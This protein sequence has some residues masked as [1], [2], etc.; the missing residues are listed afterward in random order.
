MEHNAAH[1][2]NLC[3]N[4]A[5]WRFGMKKLLLALL[6]TGPL[7][8]G[9]FGW[10]GSG[11]WE[12]R[13]ELIFWQPCTR[14]FIITHNAAATPN[15]N[16]IHTSEPDYQI[17]LRVGVGY[18]LCD[19]SIALSYTYLKGTCSEQIYGTNL[20][21]EVPNFSI[22][23][24]RVNGHRTV[25]YHN[26]NLRRSHKLSCRFQAL[27]GF[28]YINLRDRERSVGRQTPLSNPIEIAQQT[29]FYGILF[30]GGI[31][32]KQT[33][34]WGIV[35]G[36]EILALIGVG[37][38]TNKWRVLSGEGDG[39]SAY[40]G[41]VPSSIQCV[42]GIEAKLSFSKCI[43]C[44]CFQFEAELGYEFIHYFNILRHIDPI[45]ADAYTFSTY[46]MGFDGPYLKLAVRF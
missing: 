44:G 39:L 26:L 35:A 46:D 22:N 5:L 33:G 36:A 27:G 45:S 21:L 2:Y 19:D 8:G 23:L 14:D 40:G 32:A 25:E 20:R 42:P 16:N 24:S 9:I 37:D 6:S 28:R 29:R 4:N 15:H 3:V 7:F 17:G 1:V 18:A 10:D 41:H 12:A 13:G 38:Q 30:E 34:C 31:A 11:T 43:R